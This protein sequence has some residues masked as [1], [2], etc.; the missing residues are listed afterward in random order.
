[1]Q[2]SLSNNDIPDKMITWC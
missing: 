2:T 1:M